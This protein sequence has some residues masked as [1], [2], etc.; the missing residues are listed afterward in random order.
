MTFLVYERGKAR[1]RAW[2]GECGRAH[3]QNVKCRPSARWN[4]K[5]H[6]QEFWEMASAHQRELLRVKNA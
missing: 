2:C 6:A 1:P 4:A 5:R 3:G